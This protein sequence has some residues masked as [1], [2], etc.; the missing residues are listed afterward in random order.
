MPAPFLFKSDD[1]HGV[2]K[3]RS[4]GLSVLMDVA[5]DLVDHHLGLYYTDE[6]DNLELSFLYFNQVVDI[7]LFLFTEIVP[8]M[9]LFKNQMVSLNYFGFTF[10][11]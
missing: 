1:S 3:L 9:M 10:F 8:S 6:N 11:V 5:N 4:Q 7:S 2:P